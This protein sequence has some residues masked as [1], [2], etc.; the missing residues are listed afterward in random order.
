LALIGDED[1]GIEGGL[2]KT[3]Q[4][5][6]LGDTTVTP[7]GRPARDARGRAHQQLRPANPAQFR[8]GLGDNMD[9]AEVSKRVA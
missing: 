2:T 9:R 6:P 3:L 1:D 4:F 5:S 8:A 7:S